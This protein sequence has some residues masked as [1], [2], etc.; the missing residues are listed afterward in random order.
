M[1]NPDNVILNQSRYHHCFS[2]S[3]CDTHGDN[4]QCTNFTVTGVEN[5]TPLVPQW[6]SWGSVGVLLVR[7][8]T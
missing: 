7:A 2:A 1:D 6:D 5:G 8:V 3:W 4:N